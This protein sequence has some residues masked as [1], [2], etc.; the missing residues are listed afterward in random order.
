M[1]TT[2]VILT[3]NTRPACG[4]PHLIRCSA[5]G[6][7]QS[8]AH[9]GLSVRWTDLMSHAKGNVPDAPVE[10]M[11]NVCCYPVFFG[12]KVSAFQHIKAVRNAKNAPRQIIVFGTFAASFPEEIL[13]R[14]LADIVVFFDPEFV[15]PLILSVLADGTS[16][17]TIPNL[18]YMD[19]EKMKMTAKHSFHDLDAIPFISPYLYVQG[20]RP[21]YMI[22]AR[23]CQYHCVFCDRNALWG[24]GIRERSVEN[25][26]NEI[27]ELVSTYP[28][29]IIRFLDEDFVANQ[30]RLLMLCEGIRRI[31][32]KFLWECSACVDSVTEKGLLLMGHSGCRKI[33]LG[34]ESAS[35]NVL[36][37]IGKRYGRQD[38]LN[39]VGWARKAKIQ[40]EVMITTG[41]P[42]ET[43]FDHQL[44]LAA[45]NELGRDGVSITTNRLV[46]LPGTPIYRQGLKEGRYTSESF[47]EDDGLIFYNEKDLV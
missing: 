6:V 22:T 30:K 9:K 33:N 14:Q 47:F 37:R 40:V 21:A 4:G 11:A 18:A 20:D 2:D 27:R 35:P 8:V 12:N 16:L 17:S 13:S 36:R 39:A 41:N 29:E 7:F 10:N 46:I 28:V 23:G 26:L 24:G 25:V 32:G 5:G 38:I 45:L 42:Q 19:Q 34:V 31:R 1:L 15:I 44:T 43:D 3:A